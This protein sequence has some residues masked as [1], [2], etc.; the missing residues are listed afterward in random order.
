MLVVYAQNL[1]NGHAT[2]T[3]RRAEP[4]NLDNEGEG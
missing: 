4:D 1:A 2:F 3:I